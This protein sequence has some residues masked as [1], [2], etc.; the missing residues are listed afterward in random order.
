MRKIILYSKDKG[1]SSRATANGDNKRS[2]IHEVD[3]EHNNQISFKLF[4][5]KSMFCKKFQ[6]DSD[7]DNCD[8]NLLAHVKEDIEKDEDFLPLI[9]SDLAGPVNVTY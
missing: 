6:H 2:L 7:E 9:D 1:G 3:C 8:G 4:H 5:N